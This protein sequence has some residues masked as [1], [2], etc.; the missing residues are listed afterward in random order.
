MNDLDQEKAAQA[1]DVVRTNENRT[2]RAA[3][4]PWWVYA[5]TFVLVAVPLAAADFVDLTGTKAISAV[6]LALLV[7]ALVA[8]LLGRGTAPLSR[9]RGVQARRQGSQQTFGLVVAIGA[10]GT[11]LIISYGQSAGIDLADAIGLHGYRNT[12]T[13]VVFGAAFTLLFALSQFLLGAGRPRAGR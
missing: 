5:G 11:W 13:G 9:L 7:L 8:G 3:R 2:R 4:L 12:V 1:L 10:L 6:V